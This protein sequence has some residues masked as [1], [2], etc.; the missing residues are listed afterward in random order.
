MGI[1]RGELPDWDDIQ[2]LTAQL[3]QSSAVWTTTRSAR[4]W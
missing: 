4:M 2:I 3:A 1:P